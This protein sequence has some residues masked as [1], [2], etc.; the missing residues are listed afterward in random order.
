MAFCF[1]F[2]WLTW[3]WDRFGEYMAGERGLVL[4]QWTHFGIVVDNRVSPLLVLL[5][6]FASLALAVFFGVLTV[7]SRIRQQGE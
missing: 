1:G 3:K 5:P 4:E 2:G 7:V 6:G